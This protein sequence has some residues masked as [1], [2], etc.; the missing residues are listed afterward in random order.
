[1]ND[2]KSLR[3]IIVEKGV[4]YESEE[5]DTTH[6]IGLLNE[7]ARII[8]AV[9][10][11]T[12]VVSPFNNKYNR[13]LGRLENVMVWPRDIKWR[14]RLMVDLGFQRRNHSSPGANKSG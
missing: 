6:L 4:E 9:L 2:M 11:R 14:K 5:I 13:S 12:A 1:M 3:Q 8:H 10:E 7:E